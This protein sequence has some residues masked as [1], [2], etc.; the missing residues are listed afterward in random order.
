[1]EMFKSLRAHIFARKIPL[2]FLIA[3]LLGGC[4]GQQ[5]ISKRQKVGESLLWE[6]K[7]DQAIGAFKKAITEAEKE[8]DKR[9]VAHLKSLLGWSYA[10]AMRLEEAEKEIKLSLI[11]I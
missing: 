6:K 10:E 5:Y 8:G 1:M 11:H 2:F 4:A 3:F 7:F 9:E